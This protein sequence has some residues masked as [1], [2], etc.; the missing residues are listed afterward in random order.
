MANPT[1][2][3]PTAPSAGVEAP[4]ADAPTAL[5]PPAAPLRPSAGNALVPSEPVTYR[6]FN[7]VDATR[8]AIF[9]NVVKAIQTKYPIENQRYKLE[10]TDVKY[11]D[12][13]PFSLA[14][15][16]TAIMRG[17]TLQHQLTGTWRLTNKED[18]KV[19]DE[20]SGV[21]AHVP[22]LTNRGTFI[23]GGSEYTINN[24]MRL[25]PGVYSRVKEN[26]I[27]E[28]HFNSRPGTGPSFRLYM[29]PDT[30]IFRAGVG[31]S[32]LKLYPILRAMG[33]PD[34]DI[35]K[36]WGKELLQK[37]MEA[38]DPRAVSRAFAKL[39]Y[40][41]A[42]ANAEARKDDDAATEEAEAEEQEKAAE[43]N[44][45]V[46]GT[47]VTLPKEAQIGRD[48]SNR[49]WRYL[50]QTGKLRSTD[51]G[52]VLLD[53][54]KGLCESA[55]HNLKVEGVE[56]EP[57]FDNP[58]I[59]VLN[60][61]EVEELKEKYGFKW[62]GVAKI[63]QPF[64][65]YLKRMVDL[66]PH[67]W[68][69]MDRVW[70]L[71]VESPQL[72]KFRKSL[73]FPELPK[74]SK[75]DY[76]MRFHITFAVHRSAKK[77]A[78][79]FTEQRA[80]Y[81]VGDGL[82]DGYEEFKKAAA[83]GELIDLFQKRAA[84]DD[85][86]GEQLKQ[87]FDKIELDP[88]V[89]KMT[90]GQAHSNA[91]S[92]AILRASQKLLNISRGH[93]EVDDRDSLAF[94]QF[95][96]PEDFFAERINK[97]AGQAG[98]KLLWK[99]TLR[100]NLKHVPSG[101]LTPQIHSVL[102][103]SGLGQALE[104]INPFEVLDQQLRVVRTGDGGIGSLDA[105]PMESRNVQPSHFG[106]I[107]P[108]RSPE[109]YDEQT[110]VM[111]LTGWK[112]WPV[113]TQQDKL[114]CLVEGQLEY[115]VPTRL[116][117]EPYKGLMYGAETEF[118]DYLVTPNH[119]MWVKPQPGKP[120]YVPL[121][122]FE[123]PEAVS[124]L[125]RLF[126]CGGQVPI[127]GER[128]T[129]T[130]PLVESEGRAQQ[131]L[132]GYGHPPIGAHLKLYKEPIDIND[133]AEFMGWYLS[134]GSLN[135]S[136]G[137]YAV[138]IS[139]S[140][141]VNPGN[142]L[143]ISRLMRR[144]PF[145]WNFVDGDTFMVSSKQLFC[146]L[147][148]FGF[149]NDKFIPPEIF[150]APVVARQR[151]MKAV[152]A[153]DGRCDPDGVPRSLCTTSRRLAEDF[154]RLAFQLGYSTRISFEPDNRKETYLGCYIVR[155][156]VI[157]ERLAVQRSPRHPDGQYF[158]KEY[159]GKVY[160]ATVPGGL[161]HVR[162]GRSVGFWCGNSE[163]IGIDSRVTH[164]T[165]KGSDGKIYTR[166]IN[167]KTGKTELVPADKAAHSTIAFPGEMER[168]GKRVR[169]MVKAHQVEFVGPQD[170]DYVLPHH[171]QMFT[172][173]SNLVPLISGSKAGRLL[174]GAKFINQA[175]A[176][177]HPEEPLVQNLSQSGKSF[178]EIYGENVGAI[179]AK[180]PGVVTGVS[181][182]H[183]S[184]KYAD[185]TTQDHELYHNFPFNRKSL[186]H[187]TPT[188]KIGD[189]VKPG[190]LLAKSN[191]TND[192]GT[193]AV[194]HNLRVAY[195]PYRGL[196]YEDAS[197][198]SESAAKAMASE[199][200]YQNTLSDPEGTMDIGRKQ[201]LSLFPGKFKPNQI[202]NIGE[203]GTIKPGTK[204]KKG[205]PL[206]L[207]LN[208]TQIDAV[209]RG[210]KPMFTDSTVTWDHESDGVVTDVEPMKEGG[211]NVVVKAYSPVQ[212]GDKLCFDP[213]TSVLTKS[214]WKSVAELTFKDEVATLS[215]SGELEYQYPSMLMSMPYEGK[216]YYLNTKHINMLVTPEHRLWVAR[217]GQEY[218]AVSAASFYASKGE[219]QFKKDCK[220]TGVYR[221]R[222]EFDAYST[223]T[224][225]T[226]YLSS[227]LMN[228]WLE[229]LGYYISEGACFLNKANGGHQVRISQS[230]KSPHWSKIEAVLNRLGLRWSYNEEAIRFEITSVWLYA[231]LHPLGDSLT[232]YV[233]GYVHALCPEQLQI[234]LTAY[235]DGDGHRGAVWEFGSSSKRLAED[236]QVICLKLGWAVSLRETNRV[237]NW[238]KHPHWRGRINKRHLRPWWKKHRAA[239]Y[240]SVKEAMVDYVGKVYCLGV[241]NHVVYVK[242]EDKTYWSHNCGRYG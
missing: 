91:G 128:E 75:H 110:E 165:M 78:E 41:R 88:D 213:A 219:W 192:K 40:T 43:Q 79:L 227:V 20:K 81:G 188:V 42:D 206:V 200:M 22:Y 169:A 170:V 94:Q 235:L 131:E 36:H 26:G 237:D 229:F 86:N 15:Q 216:M 37:N 234:F 208:R 123:S 38:A 44:P 47:C 232:K 143:D 50:W 107:D 55:Y 24:Q 189:P 90:L 125:K 66:V 184:V 147:K 163:A 65:F 25:K 103:R 136:N 178:D 60:K 9:G 157:N 21:V 29:E 95:H 109:C 106:Y 197:V 4:I 203:D 34:A 141:L 89:T 166:M 135:G 185:G 117:G 160:C 205:D 154:Q 28:A 76:D 97:D 230:R 162:R 191:Y 218:E 101:A 132:K 222:M 68:D 58:H 152:L 3:E 124:H 113:V 112:R 215:A 6:D 53:V 121:Y 116:I 5:T 209:H 67:A 224:S 239:C 8:K 35:E 168:G 182:E 175:L 190:T 62:E 49:K 171:S 80:N 23:Y 199:H 137:H 156:H 138:R 212:E 70:F 158:A 145:V 225:R 238:Q 167:A 148:Q 217:P 30:G 164:G 134:E 179:R 64:K 82:L 180:Q 181:N 16:K 119:R 174:M 149:C 111:T 193:M 74:N 195:M 108:V 144:L 72:R 115:H 105:V 233:P 69:G 18:G 186:L 241:S 33:V 196:N 140:G 71:E 172:S 155:V 77:A 102:L 133:W 146:Y 228:D 183:I 226:Q 46:V 159:D 201:F 153:G 92:G 194:G 122:R 210:R 11:K 173:G 177:E 63:G 100:G 85:T 104:E 93:E 236:I 48:I 52:W 198:I 39:V 127:A 207:A 187:N 32:E 214:G 27:L 73:G 151:F 56:C 161:L 17:Q 126:C 176:L 211:F 84:S 13:K 231:I 12:E 204:V 61:D 242:R 129:F 139:Q 7:N 223:Y 120:G 150:E 96:G 1:G 240:A 31:Q 19:V 130:L 221:E 59:S 10:L 54:H 51:T 142:C 98:R 14:E 114:A 45:H 2:K 118:L 99:A 57:H 220:W 202:E 87:V 83:K